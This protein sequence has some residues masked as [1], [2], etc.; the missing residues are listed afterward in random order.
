MDSPKVLEQEKQEEIKRVA[1]ELYSQAP[2]W[3]TFY[4]EIFGHNGIIQQMFPTPGDLEAFKRTEAYEEV[5]Q[6]LTRLR[7]QGA[8]PSDSTEPIQMITV[9]LPKSIHDALL[10]EAAR[11]GTSMNKLCI[12]KLLQVIEQRFVPRNTWGI[13]RDGESSFIHRLEKQG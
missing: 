8:P 3:V 11:Y 7:A 9:R 5:H 1:G 4:R 10:K 12:S 6:M 13:R 2:D